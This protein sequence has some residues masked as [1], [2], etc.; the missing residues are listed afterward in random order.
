[1]SFYLTLLMTFGGSF[2]ALFNPYYGLLAYVAFAILKPDALWWYNV[3]QWNYSRVLA[4]CMLIGWVAPRA[5]FMEIRQGKH[6]HLVLHPAC[7][8]GWDRHGVHR[9]RAL[10]G[11]IMSLRF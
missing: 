4:I 11:R 6:C 9:A 5:G 3:P 2:A 8:L 1:M 10:N 7:G